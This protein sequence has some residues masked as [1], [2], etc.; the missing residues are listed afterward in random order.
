M[1]PPFPGFPWPW[2]ALKGLGPEGG[3]KG[4]EQRQ[5]RGTDGIKEQAV[6]L[7]PKK[8]Q[9]RI[10]GPEDR[11]AGKLFQPTEIVPGPQAFLLYEEIRCAAQVFQ[12]G[13][14]MKHAAAGADLALDLL[15]RGGLAIMT[16]L[17]MTGL[18]MDGLHG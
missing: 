10:H 15:S 8:I 17:G 11:G 9:M 4:R 2:H 13:G 1:R 3:G 18:G 14:Q 5:M 6:P 7:L 12:Q 16:G